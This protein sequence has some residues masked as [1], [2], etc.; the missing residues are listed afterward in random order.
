MSKQANRKF[1]YLTAQWYRAT[2][3]SLHNHCPLK[4]SSGITMS[5]PWLFQTMVCS[6]Y[7][8]NVWTGEVRSVISATAGLLVYCSKTCAYHT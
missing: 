7:S 5:W 8:R 4:Q 3:H 2:L 6:S 1:I